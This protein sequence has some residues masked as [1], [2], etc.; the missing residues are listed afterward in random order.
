MEELRNLVVNKELKTVETIDVG[1]NPGKAFTDMMNGENLGKA[2]VHIHGSILL[3][4]NDA[5]TYFEKR[6]DNKYWI[7]NWLKIKYD[8]AHLVGT[9]R[10]GMLFCK[11]YYTL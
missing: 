5:T 3:N 1:F 7:V 11:F 6:N 2:I 9:I 4:D 10:E 8:N